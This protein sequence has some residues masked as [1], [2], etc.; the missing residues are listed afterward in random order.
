MLGTSS[1][2]FYLLEF[3]SFFQ[4]HSSYQRER[5]TSSS[6]Y[7]N[8][9]YFSNVTIFFSCSNHL[10]IFFFLR[11]DI[12]KVMQRQYQTVENRDVV[13]ERSIVEADFYAQRFKEFLFHSV[14]RPM[15]DEPTVTGAYV[16]PP[17]L[18]PKLFQ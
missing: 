18:Y 17:S 8:H 9:R 6:L 16:S 15:D 3:C 10:L 11:F 7:W 14:F 13:A 4:G 1:F 12:C 5:R 2:L